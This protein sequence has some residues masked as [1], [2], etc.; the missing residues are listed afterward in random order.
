MSDIEAPKIKR[1]Y[2][3][4]PKPVVDEIPTAQ[5]PV[6]DSSTSTELSLTPPEHL[7]T[8]PKRTYKKKV[9]VAEPVVEN[10]PA[11]P[12]KPTNRI[13][14]TT[15]LIDTPPSS[16]VPETT[17]V[18]EKKPRTEKQ[19]AAFN[20]MRDARLAKQAELTKLR[21]LE[22]HEKR[23]DSEKKR[24]DAVTEKI[25]EKATEIK[26]KRQS[27]KKS[28]DEYEDQPEPRMVPIINNPETKYRN[29]VFA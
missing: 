14:Q 20:R 21:D 10:I 8:K 23:I 5:S 22:K 7:L 25:V 29:I 11:P 17:S 12:E 1:T 9:A 16:P 24:L 4:K 18:K 15:E 19:I 27:R 28:V 6:S 2:T 13:R 26:K 3:R